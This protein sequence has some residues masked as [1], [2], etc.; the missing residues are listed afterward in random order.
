MLHF[1]II[2]NP[3]GHSQSK[4]YFDRRFAAEA[5]DASF[6]EYPLRCIEEVRPLLQSLDGMNVTSPFKQQIIPY[7]QAV[8]PVAQ[9]IGA[10]NVVS[11]GVG[12]NTD[13]LGVVDA[14]RP[15]LL[16][17]DRHALI[18]GSGGAAR[19]VG[20]GL[21]QLGLSVRY[22][23]R[24]PQ[25]AIITYPDFDGAILSYSDLSDDLIAQCTV[26]ANATPLGMAPH[27]NEAPPIPYD[28]ITPHH[29]LF[30][31][32]YNPSE[33][34]FLRLARQHGARILNGEQMFLT[35]AAHAYRLYLGN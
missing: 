3:L 26:I 28:A 6:T 13:W 25:R 1:G 35:Q 18:L 17:D 4:V 15:A 7:L 30:D 33:T 11:H 16:P 21:Q 10:V 27:L 24:S 2:G 9:T 19:A 23:S 34:L 32:I 8:D 31:C 20:Y 29:L 22:V 12:Y 14:L 5:V